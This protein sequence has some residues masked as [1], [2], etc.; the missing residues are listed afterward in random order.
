MPNGTVFCG[1]PLT[2]QVLVECTECAL[3]YAARMRWIPARKKLGPRRMVEWNGILVVQIF[4][5][6]IPGNVLSVRFPTQNFQIFWLNGERPWF[7]APSSA[8]AS[9]RFQKAWGDWGEGNLKGSLCPLHYFPS[10]PLRIRE[11]LQWKSI[12]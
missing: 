11:G 9:S 3:D 7:T 4:Q 10:E 8:E 5:Y 1:W 6:Y 2:F 12:F